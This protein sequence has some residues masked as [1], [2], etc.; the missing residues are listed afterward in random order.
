MLGYQE[1][2]GIFEDAIKL[3]EAAFNQPKVRKLLFKAGPQQW[4]LDLP[5]AEH[6]LTVTLSENLTLDYYPAE[7][8]EAKCY[9]YW[10]D[11]ALPISENQRVGELRLISHQGD[12]LKS[13]ALFAADDVNWSW[14]YNWLEI[15]SHYKSW[16]IFAAITIAIAIFLLFLK[17]KGTYL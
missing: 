12:V 13:A 11:L 1:R 4:K 2:N 17:K 10:D 6:S 14:P 3:F 9:L 7:D 16:A 15:L 8:P 5:Y